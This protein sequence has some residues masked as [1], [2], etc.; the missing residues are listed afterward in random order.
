MPIAT[1]VPYGLRLGAADLQDF[2][3]AKT[4]QSERECFKVVEDEQSLKP[5]S[6]QSALIVKDQGEFVKMMLS[7]V[8]GAATAMEA[9]SGLASI[10]AR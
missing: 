6:R 2:V 5:S 9:Y 8:T 3:R 1:L 4:G 7:S 10:W